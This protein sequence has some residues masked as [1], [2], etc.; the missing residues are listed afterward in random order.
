MLKAELRYKEFIYRRPATTSRGTYTQ[1][2][3]WFI[4]LFEEDHPQIKGIG[5]C[6]LFPG[7]SIDDREDFEP[8]L[9]TVVDS[10]NRGAFDF[11][12]PFW[13]FH[14]SNLRWKRH[15]KICRQTV[16]NSFSHRHLHA[17]KILFV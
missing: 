15:K 8:T 6:S 12:T 14:P 2:N 17:V 3:V 5:E 9:K 13:N 7:L 11:A 16:Q 10:I 1:K 4:L